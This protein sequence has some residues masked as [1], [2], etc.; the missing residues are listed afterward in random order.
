M[1]RILDTTRICD[2][3]ALGRRLFNRTCRICVLRSIG[4]LNGCSW[5]VPPFQST[6]IVGSRITALRYRAE[7]SLT[8][9]LIAVVDPQRTLAAR[10]IG[11][12]IN[13]QF[14][15]KVAVH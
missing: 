1:H 7:P 5:P 9:S 2:D 13:G 14:L 3:I 8:E 15:P 12:E 10:I 4:V 11:I 6:R